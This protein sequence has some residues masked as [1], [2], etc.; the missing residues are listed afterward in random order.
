MSGTTI[1]FDFDEVYGY[2]RFGFGSRIAFDY[3]A[4]PLLQKSNFDMG[5]R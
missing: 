2:K 1:F 5:P 3:V 4:R